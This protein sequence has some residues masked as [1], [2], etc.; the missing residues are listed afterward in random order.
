VTERKAMIDRN[1]PLPV[2]RQAKLRDVIRSSIYYPPKPI[3]PAPGHKIY[4][5]L[6]LHRQ[7]ARANEVWAMDITYLAMAKGVI[8]IVVEV[9]WNMRRVLSSGD[10]RSQWIHIFASLLL[11]KKWTP[12]FGQ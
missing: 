2:A 11:R 4:P 9:D 10:Y 6:L 7:V 1:D 3:K 8:Y 5:C 12:A